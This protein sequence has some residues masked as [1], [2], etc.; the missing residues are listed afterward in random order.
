MEKY[1]DYINQ[2]FQQK[3]IRQLFVSYF[4]VGED[5]LF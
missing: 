2:V 1:V 5:P 3:Q 4:R